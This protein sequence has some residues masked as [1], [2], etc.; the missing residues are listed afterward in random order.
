MA[1]L[2]DDIERF[3]PVLLNLLKEDDD[4]LNLLR[5]LLAK[6][7]GE[8][9][10]SAR[11]DAERTLRE[12]TRQRDEAQRQLKDQGRE[13]ERLERERSTLEKQRDELL[14]SQR[15]ERDQWQAER[16]ALQK[17]PLLPPELSALLAHI[18]QDADLLKRFELP[19]ERED[20]G[21]LIAAVAVLAQ[22]DNLSRLWTM[23]KDRCEKHAG[24][25]DEAD[26]AVF[27]TALD[28]HNA[29]WPDKP[30]GLL[31][32]PPG[33]SYDYEKHQ[34]PPLGMRG[35][36]IRAVWLPGISELKLKPLVATA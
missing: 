34:R 33:T 25:L 1:K 23:Y 15:R 11:D 24:P 22:K 20:L 26:L 7:Q 36:T 2:E 32:P 12:L 6:L 21:L 28:W 8:Q 5:K 10:D 19:R 31:S 14:A 13:M 29:N 4:V 9:A 27:R 35:E 3:K 18:R 30:Y 16:D 17:R